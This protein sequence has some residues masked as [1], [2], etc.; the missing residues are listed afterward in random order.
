MTQMKVKLSDMVD[1]I[2]ST[3]DETHYYYNM[4]S[5]EILF[6][7]DEISEDSEKEELEENFDRYISLPSKYDID[8]YQI[9]EQFIWSLSDEG[10]QNRLESG[11]SGRG[12]FRRFRELTDE[13]G[14]TQKWY[15][16][17][18]STYQRIASEWCQDN[19]VELVDDYK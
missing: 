4:D 19:H 18:A 11:I 6:I 7:N 17:R 13:F 14:L 10:Q 5:G 3:D 15:D 9:M 16:F 2:E 1:S 12:A 8:D